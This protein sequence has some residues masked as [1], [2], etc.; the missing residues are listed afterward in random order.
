MTKQLKA[1]EAQ[2]RAVYGQLKGKVY[3]ICYSV[4]KNKALAEEA[5][6]ESW[7]SIWR[8]WD[9]CQD[10]SAV[11][12]WI[13]TIARNQA[14]KK[15]KAESKHPLGGEE[16]ERIESTDTPQDWEVARRR[17]NTANRILAAMPRALSQVYLLRQGQGL[18]YDEIAARV[19][20]PVGTV[21]SRLHRARAR[22]GL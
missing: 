21:R 9:Q 6:Q 17:L 10:H 8:N 3:A 5:S 12:Y 4:T 11:A 19:G 15:L 13:H 18:S 20:V 1:R 22:L 14:I 2:F 16:A 7:A